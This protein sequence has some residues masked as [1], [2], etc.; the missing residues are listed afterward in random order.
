[1]CRPYLLIPQLLELPG[2]AWTRMEITR[3]SAEAP[4]K[5]ITTNDPLSK[6][7]TAWLDQKIE[8]LSLEQTEE[9]LPLIRPRSR[10]QRP[11]SNLKDSRVRLANSK[12][13]ERDL[14]LLDS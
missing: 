7:E 14:G 8:V 11:F 5:V 9:C 3:S 10:L 2:D 1:M 4:L 12:H 6:V 13:G